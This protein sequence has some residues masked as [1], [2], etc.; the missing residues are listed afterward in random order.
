VLEVTR[1][2][3]GEHRLATVA[4]A[5]DLTRDDRHDH[6]AER[7]PSVPVPQPLHADVDAVGSERRAVLVEQVTLGGATALD[8]T[9]I[10]VLL[11]NLE[12]R[13]LLRRD[14]SRRDLR[15]KIVTVT[16]PLPDHMKDSWDTFG[17]TEDLAADDPFEELQ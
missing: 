8:R 12:R 11:R 15:S 10:T 17:W 6:A 14:K 5:D 13:G 3:G 16:A 4:P 9:T 1:R 2:H 7:L